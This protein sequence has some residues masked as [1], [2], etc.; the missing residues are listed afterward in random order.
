M[1][2][3]GVIYTNRIKTQRGNLRDCLFY[4]PEYTKG[5]V[6]LEIKVLE[7]RLCKVEKK[8]DKLEDKVTNHDK[9]IALLQ[10]DLAYIKTNTDDIKTRL[11][12]IK[13]QR[14]H[15]HYVRPFEQYNKLIWLVIASIIGFLVKM[16]WDVLFPNL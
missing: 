1:G 5:G 13:R 12:E 10:K 7:D 11:D 4:C 16:F 2:K 14:E 8:V 6:Y 15:D 3:I 9:D